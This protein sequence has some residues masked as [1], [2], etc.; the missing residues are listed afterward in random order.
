MIDSDLI[1]DNGDTLF[2]SLQEFHWV[3]LENIIIKSQAWDAQGNSVNNYMFK[4]YTWG[5]ENVYLK[6]QITWEHFIN[7]YYGYV[8]V[9]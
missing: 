3:V 4:V 8:K 7:N 2:S 1:S 5:T 9:K 6:N